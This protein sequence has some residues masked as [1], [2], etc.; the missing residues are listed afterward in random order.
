MTMKT[1]NWAASRLLKISPATATAAEP[2]WTATS[3]PPEQDIR[4]LNDR[5]YGLHGEI[6][7]FSVIAIFFFFL[8]FLVVI[9]FVKRVLSKDSGTAGESESQDSVAKCRCPPLISGK[10]REL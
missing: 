1:G 4:F 3:N 7:A 5:Y 9:P 10:Q 2:P 6:I 8:L